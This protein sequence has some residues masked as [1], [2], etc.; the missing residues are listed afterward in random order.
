MKNIFKNTWS[1]L[2]QKEKNRFSILIS[3]D[4]IISIVDILALV[5]LLWIIKF[6][7]EPGHESLSFLPSWLIDKNSVLI[8][9]IFFFLF[10]I[11]NMAAFFIAKAE[12]NFIGN[13]AI[14]ISHNN[15][16]N[17]Q[18]SSF[19]EFINVDSSIQIRKIAFQPFAFCQYMLTGIHQISSHSFLIGL[20]VIAII[21][22]KAKLFLL[23]L[24]ILLPPMI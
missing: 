14:R 12:Y 10:G 7:I 22:F 19:E 17:Y 20:T 5:L 4:I 2:G 15:L 1:V 24:I 18:Q 11:K 23:L 8:I 6:Y 13:V 21:I 9:A 16:L 3:L